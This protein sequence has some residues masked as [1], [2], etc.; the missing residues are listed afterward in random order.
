MPVRILL[1]FNM[2]L[3][4]HDPL[5]FY[6]LGPQGKGTDGQPLESSLDLL[7][8]RAQINQRAQGHVPAD[9]AVTI[10]V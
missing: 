5:P 9:S 1:D 2:D 10:E 3:G 8:G 7:D 4:S 6:P